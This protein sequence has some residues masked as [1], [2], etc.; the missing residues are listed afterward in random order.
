MP[1][2]APRGSADASHGT[3]QIL[4]DALALL[5]PNGEHWGK[6]WFALANDGG[7]VALS[8]PQ[9]CRYCGIGAVRK[10]GISRSDA[11]REPELLL[12]QCASER[13]FDFFEEIN[14]RSGTTFADVRRVFECAIK[15]AEVA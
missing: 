4:R 2:A 7:P 6:G 14:D 11:T 15:K 10:I 8:D 13:G 12:H 9:A 5:G 1:S 3:A